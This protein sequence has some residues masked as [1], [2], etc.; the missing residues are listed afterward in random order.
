MKQLQEPKE[1]EIMTIEEVREW[2]GI[3]RTKLF[4]LL[5]S[6]DLPSF[7]IG[8]RRLIRRADAEAWLE[9]KRYHPGG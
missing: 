1:R 4:S 3:G 8:T 2:L 5:L 9:G 7:K 6:G